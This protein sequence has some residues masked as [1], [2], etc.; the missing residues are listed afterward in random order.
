MRILIRTSIVSKLRIYGVLF[1]SM[2]SFEHES[3]LNDGHFGIF[4]LISDQI[5]NMQ[6]I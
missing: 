1:D 4:A 2:P 3:A 5:D 6:Q